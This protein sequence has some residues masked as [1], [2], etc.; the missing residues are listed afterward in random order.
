MKEDARIAIDRTGK[1][2]AEIGKLAYLIDTG[3][4]ILEINKVFNQIIQHQDFVRAAI[5]TL[6]KEIGRRIDDRLFK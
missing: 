1:L 4:D 2:L 6:N 3:A 5:S